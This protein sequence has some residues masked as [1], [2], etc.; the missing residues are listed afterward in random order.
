MNY[1]LRVDPE[2][3]VLGGADSFSVFQ[4]TAGEP[5][6]FWR[7]GEAEHPA[8]VFQ[9]GIDSFRASARRLRSTSSSEPMRMGFGFMVL[10][11]A[12]RLRSGLC[13]KPERL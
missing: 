10:R 2:V 11:T 8:E 6:F 5:R 9:R 7:E 12:P 13:G 1:L 3:A 4:L